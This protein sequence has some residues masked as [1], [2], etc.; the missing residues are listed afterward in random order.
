MRRDR[1]AG[2]SMVLALIVMSSLAALGSLTALSVQGSLKSSSTDRFQAVALY[3]AESGAAVAMDYLRSHTDPTYYWSAFVDQNNNNPPVFPLVSND[4]PPGDPNNP[5]SSDQKTWYHIDILN[6][7]DD[8]NFGTG[9]AD[10]DSDRR[11]VIR[12]T[13]H[14]PQGSVA[15]V[16]WEVQ[17]ATWTTSLTLIGWHVVL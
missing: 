17:G 2:N 3:A 9:G 1:Q 6:N 11:V 15:I 13:G 16:E 12:S 4:A 14:G 7:R 5:F 8:P 10:K